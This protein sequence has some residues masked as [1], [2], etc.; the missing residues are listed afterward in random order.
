MM[1]RHILRVGGQKRPGDERQSSAT[2]DQTN[3]E[4]DQKANKQT[5]KQT[6]KFQTLLCSKNK[7]L[8]TTYIAVAASRP[9]R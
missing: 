7:P 9:V 6:D 1:E 3:K 2:F 4:T 8:S 5:K